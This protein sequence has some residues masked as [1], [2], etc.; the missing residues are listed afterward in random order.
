MKN[1]LISIP[2]ILC[3]AFT[4][5]ALTYSEAASAYCQRVCTRG[6]YGHVHCYRTC[7]YGYGRG[8]GYRRGWYGH[9][10]RRW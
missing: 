3:V 8:W 9:R 1:L 4:G 5:L 7:G 6:Y 2:L 10:W